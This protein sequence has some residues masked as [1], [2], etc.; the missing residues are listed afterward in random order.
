VL[1][2]VAK[3]HNSDYKLIFSNWFSELYKKE[4][5][6]ISCYCEFTTITVFA[7]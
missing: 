2:V 6:C 7:V 3:M 4:R 1:T 5:Y